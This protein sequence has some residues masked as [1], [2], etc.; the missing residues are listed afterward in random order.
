MTTDPAALDRDVLKAF[1]VRLMGVYGAGALC[2]MIDLGARTGLT[3]ALATAPGTTY[4]VAERAG[5]AE[6]YVREWL[7]GMATGGI[8]D[9][10]AATGRF[11]L[12]PEHATCLTGD[13]FYN[14]SAMARVIANGNRNNDRLADA[15]RDGSG[16]PYTEQPADVVGLMDAMGRARYD[17]FL[18]DHYLTADED[19]HA[20]LVAGADVCD[21]GCGSGHVATLIASSFPGCRVV[22]IDADPNAI[23]VARAEADQLGLDNVRFRVDDAAALPPVAFDVI[24][25]F[26]VIHDLPRPQSTLVAVRAALRDG[27]TFLMYDASAPATLEAQVDL[28]WSTMMYG[29]SINA[30]IAN[31]MADADEEHQDPLGPMWPRE[32]AEEAL[33]DAGFELAGVHPV[34]G[35]PMNALYVARR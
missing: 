3:A 5:L 15:F 28:P 4:E 27:G 10:D 24:T 25:A 13:H 18:V 6:R 16:I 19:L 26:D 9:H 33:A 20:A 1:A 12:A 30:C 2:Q 32:R 21:I 35:D 14:T 7:H 17:T 31:A 11:S 8:V 22:G 34:K 23:S 29:I